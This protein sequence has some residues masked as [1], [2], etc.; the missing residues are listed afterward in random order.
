MGMLKGDAIF[1]EPPHMF[2]VDFYMFALG[3]ED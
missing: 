1:F 2:P 3:I